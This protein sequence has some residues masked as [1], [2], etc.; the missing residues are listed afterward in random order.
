MSNLNLKCPLQTAALNAHPSCWHNFGGSV[1]FRRKDLNNRSI[2]LVVGLWII[3]P[4]FTL[5]LHCQLPVQQ[6]YGQ[7][8]LP[9]A[10][11]TLLCLPHHNGL[12]S[13]SAQEAEAHLFFYYIFG[14]CFFFVTARKK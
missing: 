7:L 9:H 5:S 2:R 6:S 11:V 12:K 4:S 14:F 10:G 13:I 8:L 1:G 3:I